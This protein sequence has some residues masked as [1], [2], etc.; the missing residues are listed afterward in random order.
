MHYESGDQATLSAAA[1]ESIGRYRYDVFVQRL[2]WNLCHSDGV[3]QDQFDGP[4]AVYV[5]SRDAQGRMNG[6]ARLLPTLKPYLL[7]QVFPQLWGPRPLPKAAG[8]WELSRFAA[9]DFAALAQSTHQATAVHAAQLMH[10][11]VRQARALGAHTLVMVSPI[12]MERLL[13]AHRFRAMRA[14]VPQRLANDLL[15]ALQIDCAPQA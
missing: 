10:R 7:E 9:V 3:E 5:S 4:D 2:G 13:R 14:A 12:G 6:V 1:F 8:I 15:V 11:V